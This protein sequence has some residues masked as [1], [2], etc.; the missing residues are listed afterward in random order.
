MREGGRV[1]SGKLVLEFPGPLVFCQCHRNL[2]SHKNMFK[3]HCRE[4]QAKERDYFERDGNY[5]SL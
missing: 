5:N 3:Q 1:K 2:S 4:N